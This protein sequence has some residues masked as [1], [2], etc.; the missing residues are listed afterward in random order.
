MDKKK[1]A[2]TAVTVAAVAGMVTGSVFDNPAEIVPEVA[3]QVDFLQTDDD[4]AEI[5]EERQKGPASGI[6]QWIMGLPAAVRMLV[7]V[8]LWLFGSLLLSAASVFWMGASPLL[9]RLIGWVCLA[10]VLLG[11]FTVSVK[12]AFPDVPV[13]KI[14]RFRNVVLLVGLS[15]VLFAAE[16]ALPSV[17]E[18][19]NALSGMVWKIGAT[20]LLAFVC[21]MELKIRGK[22]AAKKMQRQEVLPPQ[23]TVV[24]EEARRLADTVC[25]PRF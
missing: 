11:I 6:R 17:W 20:C 3:E 24:E 25:G 2:A 16:L 19:Y 10:V 22:K 7:V 14:L 1:V 4:A 9:S 8:P 21:C 13:R 12:S 18:G 15:A 5:Q 23:R